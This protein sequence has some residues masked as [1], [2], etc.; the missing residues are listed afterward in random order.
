MRQAGIDEGGEEG[1]GED[2]EGGFVADD[3]VLVMGLQCEEVEMEE[4]PAGEAGEEVMELLWQGLVHR[5]VGFG[6]RR[7]G[8]VRGCGVV[9]GE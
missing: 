5:V 7:F 4:L 8:L 3:Y 1:V 6:W 9:A 2:G